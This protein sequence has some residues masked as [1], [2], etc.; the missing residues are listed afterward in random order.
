MDTQLITVDEAA[1]RLAMDRSRSHSIQLM[2]RQ[3]PFT[4]LVAREGW[5]EGGTAAKQKM[6]IDNLNI[7]SYRWEK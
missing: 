3:S 7:A 1:R 4:R 6:L 5:G 2:R